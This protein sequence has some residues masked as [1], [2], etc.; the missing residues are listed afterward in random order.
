MIPEGIV[1]RTVRKCV[2]EF[3][4]NIIASIQPAADMGDNKSVYDVIRKAVGPTKKLKI[5]VQCSTVQVRDNKLGRWDQ[6]V[7]LLNSKQ[8]IVTDVVLKLKENNR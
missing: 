2:N 1:R 8:D 7:S 3:W 6:H 4:L 5:S